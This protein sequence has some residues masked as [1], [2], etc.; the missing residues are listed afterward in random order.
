MLKLWCPWQEW[1][2]GVGDHLQ[3][4]GA[5]AG[6]QRAHPGQPVILAHHEYESF[7]CLRHWPGVETVGWGHPE[8]PESDYLHVWGASSGP[9]WWDWYRRMEV[10]WESKRRLHYFLSDAERAYAEFV[11]GPARPRVLLQ[12]SGGM[13]EKPIPILAGS[14][15]HHGPQPPSQRDRGRLARLRRLRC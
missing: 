12:W 2:I 1:G 3:V 10:D 11:W 8:P 6:W 4:F 13:A 5:V 9:P 15:A 7:E 14:F